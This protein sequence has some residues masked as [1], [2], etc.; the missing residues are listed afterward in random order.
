MVS[1][2]GIRVDVPLKPRNKRYHHPERRYPFLL[3]PPVIFFPGGPRYLVAYPQFPAIYAC[4]TR[5]HP[6][7]LP[8][9]N[10]HTL[11]R[12]I[13]MRP[14][15]NACDSITS[16]LKMRSVIKRYWNPPFAVATPSSPD[17]DL[18]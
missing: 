17:P 9:T 5:A 14:L 1:S 13:A 10:T 16:M 6:G 8:N 7:L 11:N 15:L 18:P 12:D 4:T 2:I 3:H